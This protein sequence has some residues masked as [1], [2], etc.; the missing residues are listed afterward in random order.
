MTKIAIIGSGSHTRSSINLL[1]DN[2]DKEDIQ[3]YD[4]SYEEGQQ[5]KINSILLTGKISDIHPSQQIFLSIGDNELRKKYFLK[6]KNQLI[7]GT[8]F[9]KT[10]FQESGVTFGIA[11]QVFSNSYINSH[12]VVGDNNIINTGAIIE[13]EVKVG[14]HNHI[15]VGAKV[16]GRSSIGSTCFICAGAIIS[17]KLSI[18]DNVV[19]GA[20]SVV[21]CDIH[22]PGTYV[23]NP[24]KK[25]K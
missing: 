7:K 6:F 14:S 21:I 15:S 25:I 13:H 22:E 5:E 1:L 19:V 4:D 12:V 3:I 17:D 18:C 10:S 16:C 8:S 23:G 9:H 20:G 11:N 2:F 24:A